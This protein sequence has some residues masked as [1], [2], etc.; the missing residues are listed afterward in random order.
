M[1]RLKIANLNKMAILANFFKTIHAELDDNIIKTIKSIYRLVEVNTTKD[2]QDNIELIKEM[3]PNVLYNGK[4]YRKIAID[5]ESVVENMGFDRTVGSLIEACKSK[6][7]TGKY[8][9]ATKSIEFCEEFQAISYSEN[10]FAIITFDT[11]DGIDIQKLANECAKCCQ[12]YING[13][14]KDDE[15]NIKTAKQMLRFIKVVKSYEKEQEVFA[16]VPKEFEIYCLEI[17]EKYINISD[18]NRSLSANEIYVLSNGMIDTRNEQNQSNENENSDN[19]FEDKFID[20][21]FE[22]DFDL[23]NDYFGYGGIFASKFVR[24]KKLT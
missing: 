10:L 24:L 14:D 3:F 23:N 11:T 9:S 16:L 20:I 18:K 21:D 5:S 13:L 17:K 1:K 6:I 2:I 12:D 7:D 19:I 15:K 4:V 22:E 8:Q